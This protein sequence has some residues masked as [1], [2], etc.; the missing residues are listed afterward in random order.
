MNPTI[1]YTRGTTYNLT[2]NYSAPLYLG[3]TLIWTVKTVQNDTDITD[4]TNAVMNPKTVAMSGDTFPQTTH[5]VINPND[6]P[7]T[8]TPGKCYYSI[9]VIDTE[10]EEFIV[11][12]GIFQLEAVP[13]NDIS[14]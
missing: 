14:A 12:N 5:I 8:Q 6:V 2:H 4:L 3:A 7:V 11:A 13:T 9:K 10:G 1:T